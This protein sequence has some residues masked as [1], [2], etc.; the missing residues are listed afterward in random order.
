MFPCLQRV[1]CV[2]SRGIKRQPSL[3]KPPGPVHGL[4]GPHLCDVE[5][6]PQL[7]KVWWDVA[8]PAEVEEGVILPE[9][10]HLAR[11]R[12]RLRERW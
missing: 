11:G 6:V 7:C 1:R 9:R 2:A 12:E 3:P 5:D 4:P 10:I 8:P